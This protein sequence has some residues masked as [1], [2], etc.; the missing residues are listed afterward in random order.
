M[1]TT[2]TP[3]QAR[4]LLADPNLTWEDV[5]ADQAPPPAESE[6]V[7]VVKSLRLPP[8]M[9]AQVQAEA[10]AR[11]VA[12]SE[13]IR[14]WITSALAD[15]ADDQPISRADAMRALASLHPVDRHTA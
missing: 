7:M 4:A 1:N 15:L 11:G 5:P 9:D 12:W 6:A 8:E 3:D 10:D 2:P 13:L 14:N